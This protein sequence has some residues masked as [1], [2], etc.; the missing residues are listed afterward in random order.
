MSAVANQ[1][2]TGAERVS[3]WLTLVSAVVAVTLS[4]LDWLYWGR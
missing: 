2:R 4:V 1:A 3:Q